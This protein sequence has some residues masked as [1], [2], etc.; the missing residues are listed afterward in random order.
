M[1]KLPIVALTGLPNSGKSTLINKLSG[2]HG[3]VTSDVAGT[4]RDRQYFDIAWD[5][6]YFSL[7]DTAGLVE[8][9]DNELEKNVAK[10]LEKA[11][12]ESSL[13]VL[14]IDGKLPKGGLDQKT[15]LKFRKL[16]KPVILAVNKIDS[17]KEIDQAVK[18]FNVLGIKA[19]CAISA[20]SGRGLGDLLS[21][22]T[23]ELKKHADLD[24]KPFEHTGIAV[25]IVGKP[26]VGKSSL[27]NKILQEERVVVSSIPGTTRTAIDSPL[28]YKDTDYIFIDTAGLKKK[29]HKQAEPDIFSGFQTFKSVRRSDV[30]M[31]VI[32]AVE[33]ITKQ[34]QK[35]AQEIFKLGKGMIILINKFDLYKGDENQLRDYISSYFPFLW[36]MPA[37]LV[38]AKTGVGITDAMDSIK[39]I[40]ER[41]LKTIDQEDIDKLLAKR[42]KINP[43]KLLRDQKKPKVFGLAQIAT[44]PP[45]FELT[46]NH[47]AAISSQFKK[48]L[49][50]AII[51]DLDFWGTPLNLKVHKKI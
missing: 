29:E 22:I 48:S 47:P 17:P 38:S 8:H 51:K 50:N 2:K 1:H 15:L 11:L 16:K 26:N 40:Y 20:L 19:I 41:R 46:V 9:Q 7:V 21:L 24:L 31:F 30:V 27:F 4:T 25:S 44:N 12:E 14:V 35:V 10:Q 23:D 3:A 43:P 36:M 32:D 45:L 49:L 5:G 39:P 6:S 18:T 28:S 13:V 33:E 37:F 34:D 42:M